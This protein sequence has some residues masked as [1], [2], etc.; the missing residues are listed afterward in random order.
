MTDDADFERF[1]D[2]T[3][4]MAGAAGL[5]RYEISNFAEEG[6]RCRHNW[7]VWHGRS[8]LGCGPAAASFDG[9]QRRNNPASL[10][11]WLRK[12]APQAD[13]LSPES[14]ACEILAFGMRTLDGWEWQEFEERTGFDARA[15]RPEQ[16]DKLQRKELV[17]TDGRGMRP[18]RKGLLFNDDVLMELL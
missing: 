2:L 4:A 12:E 13:V 15:L 1:W 7:D 14:R 11:A 5:F 6:C 16:I 3:D 18:T 9:C 8:Y 10:A 17:E